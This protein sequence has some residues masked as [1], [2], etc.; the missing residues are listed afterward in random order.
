M[1]LKSLKLKSLDY[2]HLEIAI[3]EIVLIL[4]EQLEQASIDES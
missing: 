3:E 1:R 2:Y 4:E